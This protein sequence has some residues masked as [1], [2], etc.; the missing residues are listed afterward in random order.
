[1]PQPD[2]VPRAAEVYL[3]AMAPRPS[4]T[5]PGGQKT[6]TPGRSARKPGL[7]NI[8]PVALSRF[9]EV[10]V[11][12]DGRVIP[13]RSCPEVRCG[14]PVGPL[15]EIFEQCD[16]VLYWFPVQKR[17]KAV[18]PGLAMELKIG[19]PT[20]K[21]NGAAEELCLA[22]YIRRGRT[23]VPL[24]FLARTLNLTIT[25][26]SKRGQLIISRNDL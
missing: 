17:V 9:S 15:R 5:L 6:S 26:D 8:S 24:E 14:V 3:L 12:Y 18:R 4:P 10:K 7:I 2:L 25:F 16:G 22:P 19:V 23:M 20:V 13:L 11:V 1:M 21:V